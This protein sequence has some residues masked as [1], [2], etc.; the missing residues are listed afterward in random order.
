LSS[1]PIVYLTEGGARSG[2]H[3]PFRLLPTGP[4]GSLRDH[5]IRIVAVPAFPSE[6]ADTIAVPRRMARTRPF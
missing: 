4:E 2:S 3:E 5:G 6:L 1:R